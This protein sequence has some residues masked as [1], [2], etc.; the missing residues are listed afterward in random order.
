MGRGDGDNGGTDKTT[1]EAPGSAS[2]ESAAVNKTDPVSNERDLQLNVTTVYNGTCTEDSDCECKPAGALLAATDIGPMGEHLQTTQGRSQPGV[3]Y[4]GR[5]DKEEE[6]VVQEKEGE[7]AVAR[8]RG[9]KEDVERTGDTCNA[10]QT[11][12]NTFPAVNHNKPFVS[13]LLGIFVTKIDMKTQKSEEILPMFNSKLK[14]RPVALAKGQQQ[15]GRMFHGSLDIALL[16][17]P[18]SFTK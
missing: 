12:R 10:P 2:L 9:E 14:P 3:L 1:L 17:R 13:C 8:Q 11:R 4:S 7:E 16:T 6:E 5:R 18:L 15:S